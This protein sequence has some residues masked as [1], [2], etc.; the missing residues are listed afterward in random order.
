M[1]RRF[2][3]A[4]IP[5]ALLAGAL[6]PL[7]AQAGDPLSWSYIEGQYLNTD[8]K[9]TINGIETF[10]D[11]REGF[12]T[13]L[14]VSLYKFIY[15]TGDYDKR[16][17]KDF[18]KSFQS[19]GLGAHTEPT[20]SPHL[21]LFGAATY[22]RANL[23]WVNNPPTADDDTDEGYGLQGGIRAPFDN[24]EFTSSYKYINRGKTDGFK[25][26]GDKYG[27][28]VL[29]QISP[30]FGLTADYRRIDETAKDSGTSA[31]TQYNEWLVGFRTYFATDIDRYRRRGGF[32][33]GE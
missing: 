30:Y 7:S 6:A 8:S 23:D 5:G 12:R 18:R 14:N 28:G 29:V 9:S 3:L 11:K 19:V 17:Y 32:F 20:F 26:T 25:V 33:G 21:Q 13:A 15:F 22:E 1:I 10:N 2:K 16:R 31:K 24:F 4:L 27:A